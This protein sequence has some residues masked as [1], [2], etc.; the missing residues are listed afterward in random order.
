MSE[1][2]SGRLTGRIALV[3]GASRGLGAAIA[4]AY[5]REGAELVLTARTQGGLEE[6]DDEI[7]G[8]GGKTSLLVPL[9]LR[10]FDAIDR[11]GAA[12]FERFGR[13]DV[14]VGNAGQLGTLS[15]LGHIAPKE[16]QE[17]IDVNLT[18]N[19]RLIRSLDPLLRQSAAGRAIFVT[20]GAARGARAYWGTYAVTKAALEMMVGVYAQEIQ[21]TPIRANLI[22]PGRTRTRMRAKAYP[23]EDP[24]SVKS[25]DE[26]TAR[27]VDLACADFAG[28]GQLVLS[29]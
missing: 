27:F 3:T 5:A 13:L 11:L 23:G 6:L 16:W 7:R 28:N 2:T 9:D 15:P 10:D 20:S 24:A 26:V 4:R 1:T 22:D 8:I 29:Q 14:L 21:Q 19:W 12:L 25:P 18:A 17:V